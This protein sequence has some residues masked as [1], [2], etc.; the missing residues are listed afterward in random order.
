M[1]VYTYIYT[2]MYNNCLRFCQP[3]QPEINGT[4][5]ALARPLVHCVHFCFCFTS[6]YHH[7][8]SSSL[9]SQHGPLQHELPEFTSIYPIPLYFFPFPSL[10]SLFFTSPLS[11]LTFYILL[12]L[13]RCVY[14]CTFHRTTSRCA[15]SVA[16]SIILRP[17][18]QAS[19]RVCSKYRNRLFHSQF[20]SSL[21]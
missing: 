21:K 7:Y 5:Y 19:H 16:S 14:T 9:L 1:Y 13:S 2:Q 4:E 11:S 17:Q 18:D 20:T 8:S 12:S 10:F 6:T 15:L 3:K